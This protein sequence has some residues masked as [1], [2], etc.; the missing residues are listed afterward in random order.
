MSSH[1]HICPPVPVSD[2]LAPV[3]Y[4]VNAAMH[5]VLSQLHPHDVLHLPSRGDAPA[6]Q[7]AA[8]SP[9]HS[10]PHTAAC[11][12]CPTWAHA[13]RSIADPAA[14]A[15]LAAHARLPA[16]PPTSCHTLPF[17]CSLQRCQRCITA[18]TGRHRVL[19]GLTPAGSTPRSNTDC[20]TLQHSS[21]SL[22][23]HLLSASDD[24]T[25]RQAWDA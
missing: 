10:N 24:G 5:R 22:P 19:W 2:C 1:T 20:L 12:L 14:I 21:G 25:D 23:Y 16:I 3:R 13:C 18:A 15:P 17:P 6:Q 8:A 11:T 7:P 4:T 9:T